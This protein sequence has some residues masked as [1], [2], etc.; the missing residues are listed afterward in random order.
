MTPSSAT[1]KSKFNYVFVGRVRSETFRRMEVLGTSYYV[2]ENCYEGDYVHVTGMLAT[3]S[4][5][6]DIELSWKFPGLSFNRRASLSMVAGESPICSC[7]ADGLSQVAWT[8]ST[9]TTV[10]TILPLCEEEEESLTTLRTGEGADICMETHESMSTLTELAEYDPE[11]W[12]MV[13]DST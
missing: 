12:F 1:T 4:Q 6:S 11:K 2:A 13:E 7:L 3:T 10:D 5:L 9:S 8:D